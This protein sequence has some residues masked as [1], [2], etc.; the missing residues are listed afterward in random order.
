MPQSALSKLQEILH[1]LFRLD[2]STDLDFGIYRLINLK[3]AHLSKY[4]EEQLPDKVA[5]IL[6]QSKQDVIDKRTA[7]FN[8]ARENVIK[9]LGPNAIDADGKL[10]K[11]FEDT[12]DGER[13]LQAQQ[14]ALNL[15]TAE[16]LQNEIYDHL[17]SFFSRYECGGG[18]IV[19]RRLHSIRNRYAVPYNGEET[20]LHWANRDQYYIKTAAYNP[21]IAFK[22]GDQR[23]RFQITEACDIPRDNNKDTGR[24]LL[25]QIDKIRTDD[26]A[27]IVIPFTFRARWT[28]NNEN[29]IQD[30][31]WL[32]TAMEIRCKSGILAEALEQLGQ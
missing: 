12:P 16:E 32:K 15:K 2:E 1:R 19:P 21:S 22:L 11:A 20:L 8:T 17:A 6:K 31:L 13:Y 9:T 27:D 26:N 10:K 29:N 28:K 25:P 23:F 4:L 14:D 18:D 24:F 7:H 5:E 30:W 3:R